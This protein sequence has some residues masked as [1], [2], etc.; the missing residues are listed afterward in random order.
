MRWKAFGVLAAAVAALGA[1]GCGGGGARDLAG[2]AIANPAAQPAALRFMGGQVWLSA[3]ISDSGG[4]ARAWAE[5]GKPDQTTQDVELV[6]GSGGSYAA[7]WTAPENASETGAAV[8]Y[9]VRI[10]A[11]D[12]AGNA[13]A[14]DSIT[15]TV[16]PP[17]APPPGPPAL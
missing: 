17:T 10:Q 6:R 5:I 14:S 2:P 1:A 8:T 13:T 15:L 4:I 11:R 12:K 3:D 16:Q 9:T 7:V